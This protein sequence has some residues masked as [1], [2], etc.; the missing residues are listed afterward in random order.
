M[1]K[2]LS[3]YF[4][5]RVSQNVEWNFRKAGQRDVDA[6]HEN[7]EDQSENQSDVPTEQVTC[8]QIMLSHRRNIGIKA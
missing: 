8:K 1:K 6:S 7:E 5:G 3:S 2:N 4:R